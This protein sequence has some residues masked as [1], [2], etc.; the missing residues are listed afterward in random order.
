MNCF[1]K[2]YYMV[3]ALAIPSLIFAQSTEISDSIVV[4]SP[5]ITDIQPIENY[6]IRL[7]SNIQ[8]EYI[9]HENSSVALPLKQPDIYDFSILHRNDLAFP[10]SLYNVSVQNPAEGYTIQGAYNRF[11]IGNVMSLDINI[12]ASRYYNGFFYPNQYIN[13]STKLGITLKLHERVQLFGMGQIS[14]REGINP[15]VP[16]SFGTANYYGAGIQF[17]VTNKIGFGIG[18]TNSFYKGE[19]T[20]QTFFTP[21]SY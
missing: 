2:I 12:F 21:V 18:V 20:K 14:L 1:L 3:I 11:D 13:G 8:P 6:N 9:Y 19:W 17:K 5:I 10:F 7:E 4:K 16:S 15:K